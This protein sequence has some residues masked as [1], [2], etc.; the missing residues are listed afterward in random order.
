MDRN[1][2]ENKSKKTPRFPIVNWIMYAML[3]MVTYSLIFGLGSASEEVSWQKFQQE[4][5]LPLDVDKIVVINKEL[6]EIYIKSDRLETEKYKDISDGLFGTNRGPH[7]N[8][9][10]GSV[11]SFE[12]KLLKAQEGIA[13]KDQIDV[14]YESRITL[15]NIL[16]WVLPIILICFQEKVKYSSG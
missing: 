11:E 16:S 6:A 10:I 5:L 4:M 7:Y 3:F 14:S 13:I 1:P 9:T 15:W 12:T 2:S 8:L